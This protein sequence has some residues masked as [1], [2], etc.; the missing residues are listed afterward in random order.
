MGLALYGG[1]VR[2]NEVLERTRRTLTKLIES[3]ATALT[4]VCPTTATPDRRALSEAE[5]QDADENP[6]AQLCLP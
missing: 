1:R 5:T 3:L 6:A 2:S 4:G